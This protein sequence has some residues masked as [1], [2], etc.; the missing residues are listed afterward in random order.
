MTSQLRITYEFGDYR[1]DVAEYRLF[2]EGEEIKLR[3]KVMISS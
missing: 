3:K 2:H 1:L